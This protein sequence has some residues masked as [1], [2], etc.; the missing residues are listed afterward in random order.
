MEPHR[1][2]GSP[3]AAPLA[4]AP[5]AEAPFA[6]APLEVCT[7]RLGGSPLALAALAGRTPPTWYPTAPD[8]PAAWGD[9]AGVVR[10]QFRAG[11]WLELLAPALEAEGPAAAR[12][13][14]SAAGA[15]VV[16]TTGQ[17]PGLFGGPLYVLSKAL[18]ARALADE[19]ERAT[20][21]P[22]APVFWAAT[23]DADFAEA[24]RTIVA[25]D[26]DARVLAASATAPEGTPMS[27]VPLG[28]DVAALR[29]ALEEAAGSAAYHPALDAVRAA[30][31]P[32]ATV[33]GAYVRL[34]R[35][36]LQ[37]LGVAVLDA[38]HP[39]VREGSFQLLRRALLA[40]PA[41][42]RALAE[43]SA[44]ITAAG[45]VPQVPDVPGRSL[46]FLDGDDGRK[47]RVPV[48]EARS[49]VTRVPRGALGP[50]VLLRPVVERFILPTV[51][52]VAGPGE[53]AYFAQASAVAA[54]L[55]VAPPVVV[56]RW[57]G[58]VIEPAVRRALTR[59]GV[60]AAGLADPHAV[61]ARVARRALSPAVAETIAALREATRAAGARLHAEAHATGDVVP[62]TAVDGALLAVAHR[63]DRL[64]RRY[65]AALKQRDDADT[66]AL[67]TARAALYP[68][69][70]RQERALAF[71]PL[72]ARHGPALTDA[73]LERA[74]EHAEALVQ[75][76]LAGVLGRGAEPGGAPAAGTGA[77][78]DAA[79][80]SAEPA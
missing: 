46:V 32:G 67:A 54:A 24:S 27:A 14:R 22:V 45:F 3:A 49:L 59:L 26:G 64:E 71:A 76:G 61:A 9:H 15:G 79:P 29:A 16:V 21:V 28:D 62:R 52:Y 56:P 55:A 23:D 41:I 74:S 38:S 12:L 77:A 47:A 10:Q 63:V 11:A 35:A 2:L 7:E 65:L 57:S 20:G 42:E 30:Y 18:S 33:G 1:A 4:G 13:E 39:A 68:G 6:D 69:G 70:S 5:L 58:T 66:R 51:G 36:L 60:E 50:N 78:A 37:P 75:G 17:Q 53:Y 44:E 72:L 40:A 31:V 48:A 19:I 43:R 8:S 25:V 34:L 73:M 80:A